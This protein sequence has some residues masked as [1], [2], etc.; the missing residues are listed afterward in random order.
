[1]RVRG[2]VSGGCFSSGVAPLKKVSVELWVLGVAGV[3][4]LAALYL[5][6]GAVAYYREAARLYAERCAVIA[7]P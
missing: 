5:S 7:W 6:W 3:A 2:G 4:V 1:M